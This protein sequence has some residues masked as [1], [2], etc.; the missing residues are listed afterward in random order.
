MKGQVSITF[1]C[2]NQHNYTKTCLDSILKSGADEGQLVIVDNAS[3]DETLDILKPY[4]GLHIISNKANLGCGVAW[5]QGALLQQAE[6]TVVMNNDV[7]VTS[8]WLEG[9]LEAARRES[10]QIVCPSMIEGAD[11]Y[12]LE[13][14]SKIRSELSSKYIRRGHV[15]AVCML[16]HESVWREVGYFRATPK[17]LGFEDTIFFNE[18]RDAGIMMGISGASWIHHY[19]SITQNAIRKERKLS[20]REGLGDRRNY[21]LLGKN[22]LQRKIDKYLKKKTLRSLQLAELRDF[23]YTL[24]GI[25]EPTR[26]VQWNVY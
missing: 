24:H 8:N 20:E 17:L 7:K 22:R 9:L 10:L 25:K 3:I 11:D 14:E 5:N 12:D 26:E 18:C 21:R 4:E 15:H 16:I 2:H 19:G 13:T 6:W 1:A 23:G